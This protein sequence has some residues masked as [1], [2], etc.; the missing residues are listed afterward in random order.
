MDTKD[1]NPELSSPGIM[2]PDSG[3][4]TSIE[5][6]LV[7]LVGTEPGV[8]VLDGQPPKKSP[9]PLQDSLRRFGGGLRAIVCPGGVLL[10]F[11]ISL[12][13]T[14]FFQ[15]IGGPHNRTLNLLIRPIPLPTFSTLKL[16]PL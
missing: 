6:E 9:T 2:A 3:P 16:F 8:P 14:F 12:I 13:G 10:F 4:A 11:V 7:D 5:P 1:I 15:T